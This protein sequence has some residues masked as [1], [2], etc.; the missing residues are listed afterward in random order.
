MNT[1]FDLQRYALQELKDTYNE[2]EIK[3]LCTLIFCKMLHYTNI[4]IHLKKHEFLAK[5]F[6]DKF[7]GIV[8][9]LKT[10]KP[11]QYILGE[12]EFAG[13]DFQLNSD[14]LIPRPETEELVMWMTESGLES[15]MKVLDVGTGSGCIIVSLGKLVKGLQLYGVDISPE[16]VRQASDNARQNGVEVEFG[17]RDIMHYEEWEWARFDVIVSNPPYV[18]ESEKAL[19]HDRVLN[20]EPG[21]AL[22]VSDDDPLLFYRKIAAFGLRYLKPEGLLFF[23]INEAFGKET[24]QLLRDMGYREV[25]LRR[26]INER[27]RMVKAKKG[28]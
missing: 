6:I 19:M 15:G 24:V 12:T 5:S 11:I 14:T 7:C 13:V 23:E 17:V 1:M 22:F 26:D 8:A 25:E 16:A 27:E 21:R 2:H 3:S 9:E 28:S 18:R 4:E 20:Y 10:D